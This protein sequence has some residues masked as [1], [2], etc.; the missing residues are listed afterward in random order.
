MRNQNQNGRPRVDTALITMWRLTAENARLNELC[1]Q[2]KA[3]EERY[4][5]MLR[6]GDHRIK[7][8]LQ[9]VASLLGMQARRASNAST[10]NVLHAAAARV[11]TVARIHDALQLNNA[12]NDVVDL[13]ALVEKMCASLQEMTGGSDAVQIIVHASPIKMALDLA[14]PIV[15]AVNELIINALRHA[16]PQERNGSVTITVAESNGQ[17]KIQVADDGDGLPDNYAAGQG[18]GMRLVKAMIAKVGGSLDAQNAGGARFTLTA[19]LHKAAA[20]YPRTSRLL[21]TLDQQ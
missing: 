6:E 19:P 3:M 7:N 4:E 8:S 13:G 9:V 1:E 18:Y 5:L 15:L 16:F 21:H 10:R 20:T 12:S 11:Q 14:Q 2:H 17:L